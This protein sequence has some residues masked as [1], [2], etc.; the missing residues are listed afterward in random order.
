[1]DF[2]EIGKIAISSM[3]VDEKFFR[4]ISDPLYYRGSK[5]TSLKSGEFC[6]GKPDAPATC[7]FIKKPKS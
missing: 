5:Y 7:D 6:M 2:Q 3:D 1:M 4:L